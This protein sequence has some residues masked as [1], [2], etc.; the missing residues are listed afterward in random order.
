MFD[1][2]AEPLYP[3]DLEPKDSGPIDS[4]RDD[5]EAGTV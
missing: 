5:S 2:Y 4:I 1:P 3:D